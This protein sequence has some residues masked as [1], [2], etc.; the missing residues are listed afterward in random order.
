MSRGLDASHKTGSDHKPSLGSIH[1]VGNGYK[2]DL[3]MR[4]KCR[5]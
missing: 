5:V 2:N 3:D 4:I 1:L